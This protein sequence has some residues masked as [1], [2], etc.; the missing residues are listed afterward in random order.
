VINTIKDH[1]FVTSEYPIILSVENHC[2]LPQQR[3]MAKTFQEVFGGDL[4]A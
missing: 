3:E 2:S 4:K 1:A